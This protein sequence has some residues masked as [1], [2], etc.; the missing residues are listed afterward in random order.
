MDL[1][2]ARID[3][4]IRF[5][6]DSRHIDMCAIHTALKEL[7]R[8]RAARAADEERVRSVVRDAL[9]ELF[10]AG[11]LR[12][13]DAAYRLAIAARAAKQLASAAVRLSEEELRGLQLMRRH[14]DEGSHDWREGT[15]MSDVQ[16]ARI[17]VDR[18]LAT[19]RP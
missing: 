13:N 17:A 15:A 8:H 12:A 5:T 14:L 4:L 18:L 9:D 6:V 2:D 3:E 11:E 16:S 7:Q 1:T 19:V 10:N